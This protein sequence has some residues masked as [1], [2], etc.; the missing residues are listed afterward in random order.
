[1]VKIRVKRS[2]GCKPG[3]AG[4]KCRKHKKRSSKAIRRANRKVKMGIPRSQAFREAWQKT[5]AK[6]I[7]RKHY[8]TLNS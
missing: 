4:M 7:K 1:M 8:K 3:P 2:F 5:Y 6:A